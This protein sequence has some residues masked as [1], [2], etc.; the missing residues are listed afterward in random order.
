MTTG[1]VATIR[2][3]RRSLVILLIVAALAAAAWVFR[4]RLT[5]GP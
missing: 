3:Q 4:D 2:K 5:F 1:E